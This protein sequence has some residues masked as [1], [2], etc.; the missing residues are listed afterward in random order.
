MSE[1]DPE[2]LDALQM[3]LS[4]RHGRSEAITSGELSSIVSENAEANPRTRAAIKQ[5]MRET[6]MPVIGNNAGYYV[7]DGTRYSASLLDPA[8]SAVSA[9]AIEAEADGGPTTRE[10]ERTVPGPLTRW[11][12]LGIVAVA[13]GEVA[14]L[15]QRGDL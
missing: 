11:V 10:E 4:G 9:T 13:L 5:L 8:E 15:R 14:F 6:S 12:A 2:A 7:A 3:E 1:I